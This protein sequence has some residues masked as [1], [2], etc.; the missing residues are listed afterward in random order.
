MPR[1]NKRNKENRT[2]ETLDASTFVERSRKPVIRQIL[3][4]AQP[5]VD[6]WNKTETKFKIPSEIRSSLSTKD[7]STT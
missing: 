5:R 1:N 2:T 7:Q 3:K 6:C 4:K